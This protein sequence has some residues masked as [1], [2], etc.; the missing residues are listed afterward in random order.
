VRRTQA[1]FDVSAQAAA[2]RL[3]QLGY[4]SRRPR[5]VPRAPA[6]RF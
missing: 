4:L 6:P 2:V 5:F 3:Q 1:A